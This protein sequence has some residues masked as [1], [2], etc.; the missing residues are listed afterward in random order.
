MLVGWESERRGEGGI[1]RV[2]GGEERGSDRVGGGERRGGGGGGGGGGERETGEWS[3]GM[4]ED[5]TLMIVLDFL[6][7]LEACLIHTYR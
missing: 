4:E 7:Q 2:E 5:A 6:I 1:G 3:P